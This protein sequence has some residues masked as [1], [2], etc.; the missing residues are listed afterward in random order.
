MRTAPQTRQENSFLSSNNSIDDYKLKQCEYTYKEKKPLYFIERHHNPAIGRR[1]EEAGLQAKLQS[2]QAL[3]ELRKGNIETFLTQF[4]DYIGRF[5]GITAE[6]DAAMQG[7]LRSA[8]SHM[9]R[10]FPTLRDKEKIA[11]VITLGMA[12]SL[13]PDES[14][15]VHMT[16]HALY[17]DNPVLKLGY[18]LNE[19]RARGDSLLDMRKNI[20]LSGI[21]SI[22]HYASLPRL[23]PL[24]TLVGK[25][26]DELCD[27]V[28]KQIVH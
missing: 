15:G 22:Q 1:I 26:F 19:A 7:E 9:R 17:P 4:N 11:Y 3:Q 28:N 5:L 12:H 6:R 23:P 13:K 14:N 25:S 10:K 18:D 24:A 2:A 21:L 16:T 20:L 27:I 8:E